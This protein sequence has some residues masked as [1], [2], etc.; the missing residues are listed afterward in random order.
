ML[1]QVSEKRQLIRERQAKWNGHVHHDSLL[2][3][4]IE[5]RISAKR[6]SSVE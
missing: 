6:P 5:G 1:Q 2:R 4:I 3:D